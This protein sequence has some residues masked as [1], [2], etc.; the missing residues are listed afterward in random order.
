MLDTGSESTAQQPPQGQQ[1]QYATGEEECLEDL[2]VKLNYEQFL[3]CSVGTPAAEPVGVWGQVGVG[4]WRLVAAEDAGCCC[5]CCC[6]HINS[7][8]QV[9]GH[10]TGSSH[11]VAEEYPR[12]KTHTTQGDTRIYHS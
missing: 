12:E 5:C 8:N 9:R 7:H 3:S 6:S 4:T 2:F 10:R 11:S 1:E